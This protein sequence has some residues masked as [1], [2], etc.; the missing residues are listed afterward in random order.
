M[1]RDVRSLVVAR[2]I[3]LL[4]EVAEASE[5]IGCKTTAETLMAEKL[6]PLL[7]VG[8][9]VSASGNG[10]ALIAPVIV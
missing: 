3:T 8:K 5:T 1:L 7:A 4:V 2:F 9:P 10:C 6:A